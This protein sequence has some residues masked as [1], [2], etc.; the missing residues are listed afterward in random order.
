MS[1]VNYLLKY[2]EKVVNVYLSEFSQ[3]EHTRVSRVQTEKQIIPAPHGPPKTKKPNPVLP[4]T[5]HSQAANIERTCAVCEMLSFH[6]PSHLIF[7]ST[8]KRKALLLCPF[9]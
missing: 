1:Y 6:A 2:L 4:H 9:Y 3:S 7:P 5:T 8:S